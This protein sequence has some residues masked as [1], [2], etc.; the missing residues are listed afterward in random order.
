MAFNALNYQEAILINSLPDS[1]LFLHEMLCSTP[2][3]IKTKNMSAL[4]SS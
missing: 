1:D 3:W 2:F 4:V